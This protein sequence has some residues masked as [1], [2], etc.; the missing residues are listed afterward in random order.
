MYDK[1][2]IATGTNSVGLLMLFM[3]TMR[4]FRT[5]NN[6][7]EE[8]RV[9][10]NNIR[11]NSSETT[12]RSNI[13]FNQLSQKLEENSRKVEKT[14]SFLQNE[15]KASL[16]TNEEKISVEEETSI[17]NEQQDIKDAIDSLMIN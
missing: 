9:E 7:I 17:N 2:Q 16:D 10:I 14:T 1:N 5:V 6:N 3:Y 12:K 15:L 11:N 13:V 4:E 8:I